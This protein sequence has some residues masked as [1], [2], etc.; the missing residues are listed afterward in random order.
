MSKHNSSRPLCLRFFESCSLQIDSQD[1][2]CRLV[3]DEYQDLGV[4]LH[5]MVLGLK[6]KAGVR[7]IAV[8]DPDQSIYG[9][10]GA[11]PVL[12][13][14]LAALPDVEDIELKLN[15]RCADRIIAASKTLLVNPA[16]FKS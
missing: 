8:G 4:P 14:K 10:T 3:I 6:E 16:D 1:L 12:L 13:R 9:F 5:R 7:I 11:Q 2:L 15:Y